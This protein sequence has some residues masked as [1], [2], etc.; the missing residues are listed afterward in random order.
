M[1]WK[2]GVPEEHPDRLIRI[3]IAVF[4]M[5]GFALCQLNVKLCC[6]DRYVL[7]ARAFEVHLDAGLDG[8][9]PALA[10]GKRGSS[11]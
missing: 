9:P 11:A 10:F 2:S 3:L 1:I 5:N 8:V 6:G 4:G 7:L